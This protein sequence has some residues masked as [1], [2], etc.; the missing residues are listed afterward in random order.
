MLPGPDLVCACPDCEAIV[1][2]GSLASWN[3]FGAIQ[4]T[5]GRLGGETIPTGAAIRRCTS[6][7]RFHWLRDL[8]ELGEIDFFEPNV[9]PPEA[10]TKAPF[11]P[12]DLPESTWFEAL[13]A[14]LG[15]TIA[16]EIRLR[17]E[18]FMA[19]ND[20]LRYRDDGRHRDATRENMKRLDALLAR[21]RGDDLLL[22]AE[23]L[24]ELGRFAEARRLLEPDRWRVVEVIRVHDVRGTH[25]EKQEKRGLRKVRDRL[26]ELCG[27][28]DRR[29]RPVEPRAVEAMLGTQLE[30]MANLS[31]RT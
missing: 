31:P 1:R 22:R 27:K 30:A 9:K 25:I 24:R 15:R 29:V 23:I 5:D 19:A 7:G 6:C 17:Y 18:A 2:V 12:T 10:W 13:D 20:E 28:R 14:G 11:V 26:L 16:E 4:W 8:R 3:N 21:R